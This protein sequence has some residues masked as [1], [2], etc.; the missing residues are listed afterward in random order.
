MFYLITFAPI[1]VAA[2]IIAVIL[3]TAAI[4]NFGVSGVIT[5]L[6]QVILSLTG[7]IVL[8]VIIFAGWLTYKIIHWFSDGYIF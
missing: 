1:R 6:A 7:I 4:I 3:L 5:L 2:S 8:T